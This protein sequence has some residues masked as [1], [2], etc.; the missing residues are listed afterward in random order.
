MLDRNNFA[1]CILFA[2]KGDEGGSVKYVLGTGDCV[3]KSLMDGC[4]FEL[5]PYF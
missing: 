4:V 2:L 5:Y 3:S 1:K